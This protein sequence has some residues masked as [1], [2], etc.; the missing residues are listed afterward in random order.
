MSVREPPFRAEHIGSLLRP[1]YLIKKRYEVA[2][3]KADQSELPAIEDKSISE[4]VKLQQDCGLHAIGD[5]EHRRHQFWGTFFETLNGMSQ[6]QLKQRAGQADYDTSIFRKYAPDISSF[7]EDK[8][9]PNQVTVATGKVSHTGNSS[10]L[11]EFNYLKTILPQ[12]Q[13]KNVKITLPSPSWYHY[14]Y[15]PKKAYTKEAY[16]NDDDYFED[17]AKA[18]RTELDILYKAGV[19]NVQCDDP[20]TA[21]FCS[22]KMLEGWAAD[23][24]NFQTADEQLDA[25]ITFYNKCFERPS[26]MHLGIHLCRGNYMGS[27]HFSEG[28]YDKIAEKLFRELNVN[29][30][31]LEYDTPRAGSFE[32]LK[33]LPK[34]KNVVLG[35]ITS[36]F[37]QLE[38]KQKMVDRVYEAA[39]AIATGSGQTREE[40]LQRLSVSPQ[41]GFASHAEGNAL[42]LEDMKQKLKLVRAI[43]DEVWPG[44]P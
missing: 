18:Y 21:Y 41:C 27:R 32:P 8:V 28:A 20:N 13:W 14:R 44:Q 3:G 2:D 26:D 37:P 42:E 33:Y 23:K 11:P 6:L 4:I 31:Y 39:D 36:K 25:Y 5:G 34:T 43:A 1:E 9:I 10:Y 15:G 29:T 40:A 19:R 38:D 24:E 16:T 30:F 7:L 22:E 35:V 12:D 17:I